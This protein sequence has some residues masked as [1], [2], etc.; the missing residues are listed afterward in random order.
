VGTLFSALDIARS[1]MQ[2]A[3]I[4]MDVAGHNIANVNKDGFSRQRVTLAAR[5]P[6]YR[7]FGALGRGVQVMN[8]ERIRETF[9]DTVF[10]QQMPE[11]GMA[12][13]RATYFTRLEDI[14]QEPSDHGLGSRIGLFF[15]ALNDFANNVE[16]QPVRLSVVTEAGSLA[17]TLHEVEG[18]LRQL[19]MNA[20][21][22][23]RNLVPEINSLAE[24]VATMNIHVR[25]AEL[26][27]ATAND[28]RDERDVL[29]DDLA[30]LVNITTRERPDGQ[31]D[32]LV[33]GDVLVN[34]ATFRELVAESDPTL[35][36]E[37]SDLMAIRFADNGLEVNL[38]S[39]ELLGALTVRDTVI[40]E[41]DARIDQMAATIIEQLNRIHAQ[42]NGL[43]NL[44]GILTGANAAAAANVALIDAGLPSDVTTGTLDVIVYDNAVPPNA[45]TTTVTIGTA[46]TL[47][48][49]VADL[50]A[51]TNLSAAVGADGVSLELDVAAPNTVVF[52]ND[53]TG[54]A[55]ALGL[56]TDENLAGAI[57]SSN[58][59]RD[60]T[61]AL[62]DSGLPF[63]VG[64][65]EVS[66]VVYDDADPPNVTTTT[67]TIDATTTLQS[68][69]T[70]LNAIPDFSAAIAADGVS[71][72]L[73]TTNP[74]YS[75][76]FTN[77]T[78]GVLTALGVNG[79]FTGHDA[80]TIAVNPAILDDPLL[81]TSGFSLD[82]LET[83][84]N[85]AARAMA[86]LR[87][88]LVLE[89]GSASIG[90]YYEST[91]V[92]VGVNSRSNQDFLAVEQAFVN[93]FWRRRQE[94]SG[95]SLDE[96]VTN[97]MQYQRA[98]EASARVITTTDR[99]LD[100]LL[101]MI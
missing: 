2:A 74:D 13:V 86:D 52:A 36:P 76:A 81:L 15:D 33:G 68:L 9:L 38:R 27:G 70:A 26:G 37:R 98:F 80:R 20:N 72:E 43:S 79:L 58:S 14:F 21:E 54:L 95:V 40:V 90:D 88:A 84:D 25:N 53:T 42:G 71:L 7:S 57:V 87:H 16:G 97:M 8:I 83:G 29:L 41:L 1:G 93:D 89:G 75:F 4:Q 94:V 24:R 48:S 32:V 61:F 73:G 49:L 62:V 30:R 3:Q 56:R 51:I 19:R 59:V 101:N 34:G 55:A 66:V 85:T 78:A 99:M 17:T 11:L 100:A 64:L 46:T 92:E 67:V 50:G 6:D 65:G 28:M 35:D 69:V 47:D 39:G 91:I 31:I 82:P 60:A 10:R 45:T 5:Y 23:A 77:D 44:S 63:D 18:R 12:E 96:E 22:E